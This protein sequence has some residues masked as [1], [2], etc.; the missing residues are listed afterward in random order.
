M[1]FDG[2]DLL[3]SRARCCAAGG[4]GSSSRTPPPFSIRRSRSDSRWRSPCWCIARLARPEA[5]ARATELLAEMGIAQAARGHALLPAPTVRRHEAARRHSDGARHRTRTA[6]AGRADHGARCHRGST[7]PRSA[8][9]AAG[10]PRP[11]DAAGQPQSRDRRP[12]VRSGFGS[13]CRPRGGDRAGRRGARPP[14]ASLYE[15]SARRAA[16]A[17]SGARGPVVVRSP[18]ACPISS[19]SMPGCNFRPRCPFATTGCEQAPGAA[20]RRSRSALSS[21]G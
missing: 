14:A 15:G 21:D 17:G 8:G 3:A 16:P 12:A 5:W 4:S 20:G 2:Q 6:A 9:W 7:D 11:V 1:T 19:R 18:A 10:Q 13:L